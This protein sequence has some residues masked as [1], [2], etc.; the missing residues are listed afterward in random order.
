MQQKLKLKRP[1]SDRMNGILAAEAAP[2][3]AD[4]YEVA[5]AAAQ[6]AHAHQLPYTPARPSAAGDGAPVPTP[7]RLS[8]AD[9]EATVDASPWKPPP[10]F[11]G[12][13]M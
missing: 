10:Q 11:P 13:P 8:E 9:T 4:P 6:A 3:D 2:L 1:N 7:S 12:Q 5:A